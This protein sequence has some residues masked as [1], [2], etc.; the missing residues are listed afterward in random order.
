[1][2]DDGHISDHDLERLI[3]G[4]VK[5]EAEIERRRVFAKRAS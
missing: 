4:T 2:T 5:D 1:M 3:L